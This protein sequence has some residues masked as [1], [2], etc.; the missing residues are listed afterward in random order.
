MTSLDKKSPNMLVKLF[1]SSGMLLLVATLT[2]F[3]TQHFSLP[4]A[5]SIQQ[6][7]AKVNDSLFV[8]KYEVS[9]SEY[10]EFLGSLKI[11]E[12]SSAE[13]YQIDSTK[14][15]NGP[16][17]KYYH[18]HPAY[19]NY[20]VVNISYEAALAYCEWLTGQYNSDAK[21]KFGKVKFFLPSEDTWM[22]VASGGNKSKMYPWS[23]Y[24]LRNR[25]GQSLCN[26]RHLGDESIT[27]NKA[28]KEYKIVPEFH[29]IALGL[30][31]VSIYTASVTSFEAVA[32]YNVHNM[33][34][35]V[36]E[37]VSEKGIAKG[38]SYNSP[39]YDVRIQS[40]MNYT[41]A[42]PEV[43]FRVFMKIE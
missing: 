8:C 1:L 5:K 34:G 33:S 43:G 12:A 20:P 32:P 10:R 36:A 19:A 35:N 4:T 21:R 16:M 18:V 9:N 25:N 11:K 28:T 24:Y 23:N 40:K 15:E 39:G 7:M 30:N 29:N 27:Y 26:Y 38:G 14:W 3:N 37:M 22:E 2:S 42:S 6:A 17:A 31:D 13:K 41:D